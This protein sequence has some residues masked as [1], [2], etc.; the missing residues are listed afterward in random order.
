MS[1]LRPR[2]PIP[3]VPVRWQWQHLLGMTW[4]VLQESPQGLLIMPYLITELSALMITN[5]YDHSGTYQS[6]LSVLMLFPLPGMLHMHVLTHKL[7]ITYLYLADTCL[8]I[9]F[10]KK[11]SLA[12]RT[13]RCLLLCPAN[14][15]ASHHSSIYHCTIVSVSVSHTRLG[16][17]PG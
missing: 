6:L 9:T 13:V 10:S 14:P 2:A 1:W 4:R 8:G 11:P 5:C 7:T 3:W 16:A 12:P 17:P 15:L